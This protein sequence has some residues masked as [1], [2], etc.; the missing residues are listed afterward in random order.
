[1]KN[2]YRREPR[3]SKA[4]SAIVEKASP[5][6]MIVVQYCGE[7]ARSPLFSLTAALMSVSE[8]G[9]STEKIRGSKP[10]WKHPREPSAGVIIVT[11]ACR[12]DQKKRQ[13]RRADTEKWRGW[14]CVVFGDMR[15][16]FRRVL[17]PRTLKQMLPATTFGS[18][19]SC[20]RSRVSYISDARR[21]SRTRTLQDD[22]LVVYRRTTSRNFGRKYLAEVRT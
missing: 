8:E 14:A 3:Q 12:V 18:G 21:M 15:D 6:P 16:Q 20:I 4:Y 13:H 1:M 11:E 19:A 7:T 2:Q 5:Q 10:S 17:L 9:C 22:A